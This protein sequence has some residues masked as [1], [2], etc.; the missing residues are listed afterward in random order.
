MERIAVVAPA[1]RLREVLAAMAGAGVVQPVRLPGRTGGSAADAIARMGGREQALGANAPTLS[2]AAPDIAALER[3]GK[4]AE[5]AGEAELQ[6]VAASAGRR[7]RIVAVAGWSPRS[8]V[9][10]LAERLS[11]CGG[12]VSL[13]PIS[14][15]IQPP[16]LLPARGRSVE[17][18]PLV[19]TYGIVPYSDFNP[20]IFAGIAY[21]VMFGMMFGDVGHGALVFVA[22]VWMWASRRG[23]VAR[24]RAL[25]PFVIGAGAASTAFG[26]AYGDAFGPTGLVPTLWLAPLKSPLTL[27][28][29]AIAAGAALLAISYL[30]GAFNRWREAGFWAALL[31]LP[32]LAGMTIYAGAALAGLGWYLH[33][34][35]IASGGIAVATTGLLLTF[36]GLYAKAG[37]GPQGAIEAAIE[38]FDGVTGIFTNTISFTRLGA[39]G[40]THAALG[41][42]IWSGTTALWGRGPLGWIGAIVL[43]LAGNAITFALEALV[44]AIQA[45][46]LEYYEMFSRIFV[47]EG[48][49]FKPW[50]VPVIANEESQ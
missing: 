42:I 23:W 49:S 8:A 30:L 20:S 21:V 22:G 46:R 5:L 34:E 48:R 26:F 45:L 28:G 4:L 1:T 36:L 17:F 47:S 38:L 16:T 32:G 11:A 15:W 12:A 14:A 33:R 25:A 37:G 40:L 31:A 3:D 2:A 27:M 13:R 43:F 10:A 7:G 18:Q 6:A 9:P 35:D 19:D 24:F 50:L 41:G 39:F 44:A 29:A